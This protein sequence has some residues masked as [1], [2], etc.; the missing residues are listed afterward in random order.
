[1]GWK[2]RVTLRDELVRTQ[3]GGGARLEVPRSGRSTFI[4]SSKSTR[5]FAK[6][7]TS[8]I[9][10]LAQPCSFR[11]LPAGDWEARRS[12]S[13]RCYT[14]PGAGLHSFNMRIAFLFPSLL[15]CLIAVA[16][17]ENT[18]TT[19][20]RSRPNTELDPPVDPVTATQWSKGAASTLNPPP[21]A[22]GVR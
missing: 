13:L 11:P 17:C 7:A 21:S 15:A 14:R 10:S 12:A 2:V 4:N 22:P 6:H 8:S 18:P 1:M 5:L 19:K 16:A 3:A 20:A 9:N